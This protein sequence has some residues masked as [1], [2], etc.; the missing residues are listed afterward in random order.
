MQGDVYPIEPERVLSPCT[1][2]IYKKTMSENYNGWANYATWRI[3]LELWD[4]DSWIDDLE[5]SFEDKYA[6]QEYIKDQTDEIL[7]GFGEKEDGV[8]LDY[9][10]AFV[11][12]VDF[13]EIADSLIDDHPEL[14]R[15]SEN[16]E[17]VEE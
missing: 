10:R 2:I 14:L 7:T 11:A 4:D 5:Q 17:E 3:K 8:A 9:A 1:L 15:D 6:L 16:G 12:D 13:Y